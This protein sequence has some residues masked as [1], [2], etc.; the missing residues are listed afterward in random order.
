MHQGW[1]KQPGAQRFQLPLMKMVVMMKA[2]RMTM[3]MA[4]MTMMIIVEIV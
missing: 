1:R 3:M 4:M 2:L